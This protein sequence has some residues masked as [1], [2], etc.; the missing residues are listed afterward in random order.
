M[1]LG[2]SPDAT[3][4]FADGVIVDGQH[5]S[6]T[7]LNAKNLTVNTEKN[8]SGESM[9]H[10]AGSIAFGRLEV[11]VSDE[12]QPQ[13][14][15]ASFVASDEFLKR[16]EMNRFDFDITILE[17][18]EIDGTFVVTK[19]KRLNTFED[20]NGIA[21]RV[22]QIVNRSEIEFNPDFE[23]AGAFDF[24]LP[25]GTIV[26]TYA[27]GPAA[28][29]EFLWVDGL[30][31]PHIAAGI[32]SSI[33]LLL[34]SPLAGAVRVD[35][36]ESSLPQE[37]SMPDVKGQLPV[38]YKLPEQAALTGSRNKH[39]LFI[40]PVIIFVV[41]VLGAG[42]ALFRYRVKNDAGDQTSRPLS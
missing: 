34:E 13:L 4:W 41:V 21:Y 9:L 28:G 15:R 37:K 3:G 1:S 16:E 30:L 35:S 8:S 38:Q 31:V 23:E 32:D 36:G 7:L 18:K 25:N 22:D 5:F 2:V 12:T 26:E 11:W 24:Y 19:A 42:I 40:V 27:G 39:S 29:V 14:Q 10:F 33:D 6:E 20:P 17:R